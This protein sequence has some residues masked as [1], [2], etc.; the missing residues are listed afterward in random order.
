MESK[1]GAT[2]TLFWENMDVVMA[3]KKV[4]IVFLKGFMADNAK[5]TYNVVRMIYGDGDPRLPM[6]GCEHTCFFPLDCQLG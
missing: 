2:L 4:T 5:T 6:V 3:Y 1:D